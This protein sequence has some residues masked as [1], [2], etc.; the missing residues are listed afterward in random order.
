MILPTVCFRSWT[1]LAVRQPGPGF[2]SMIW[3]A[4]CPWTVKQDGDHSAPCFFPG[5][6]FR[7][8]APLSLPVTYSPSPPLPHQAHQWTSQ[9]G[10][11]EGVARPTHRLCLGCSATIFACPS[12]QKPY[13]P[14]ISPP[15]PYL[16][17]AGQRARGLLPQKCPSCPLVCAL[18][19]ARVPAGIFGKGCTCHG[20][21]SCPWWVPA[22]ESC[23]PCCGPHSFPSLWKPLLPSLPGHLLLIFQDPVQVSL[24]R[25]SSLCSLRPPAPPSSV[26]REPRR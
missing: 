8:G 5:L 25:K 22:P 1:R 23:L 3:G 12:P 9:G 7:L 6:G 19:R 14:L 13:L 15:S 11:V 16:Q 21:A 18:G 24:A 10:G 4:C 17:L 2:P 26:L 20:A